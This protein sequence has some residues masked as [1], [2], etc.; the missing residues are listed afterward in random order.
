MALNL[1]QFDR[2]TLSRPPL[3][4]VVCQVR[5]SPLLR[6]GFDAPP[7]EFGAAISEAFPVFDPPDP[8]LSKEEIEKQA[9]T[10]QGYEPPRWVFSD[11][12]GNW[13]A[14]LFVDFFAVEALVY[15]GFSEFLGRV[16]L[17]QQACH[18]VYSVTEANRVGLRYTNRLAKN[19]T[20]ELSAWIE[21]LPDFYLT[22]LKFH[23]ADPDCLQSWHEVYLRQEEEVTLGVRFGVQRSEADGND[24]LVLDLDAFTESRVQIRELGS[25]LVK[26]HDLVYRTFRWSIQGRL[27]ESLGPVEG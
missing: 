19:Q 12:S 5:F 26:L 20:G 8:L 11:S 21:E 14:F 9:L 10:A 17:V 1:P 15:T 13:K 7:E 16:R 3:E 24:C 4:D 27:F 25:M 2:V 6:I 23:L 18:R 22:P